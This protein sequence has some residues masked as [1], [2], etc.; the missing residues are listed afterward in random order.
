MVVVGGVSLDSLD[1][2]CVIRSTEGL[3][4][5]LQASQPGVGNRVVKEIGF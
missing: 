1:A 5:Q 3:Q 2:L 4:D